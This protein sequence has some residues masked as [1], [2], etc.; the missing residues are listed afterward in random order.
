MFIERERVR[1][2]DVAQFITV[3]LCIRTANHGQQSCNKSIPNPNRIHQT[4]PAKETMKLPCVCVHF[5]VRL[6]KVKP[7]YLIAA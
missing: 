7:K 4:N 6:S 2:H 1:K 3:L 5:A